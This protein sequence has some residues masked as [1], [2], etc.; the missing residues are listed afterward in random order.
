MNTGTYDMI[1]TVYQP[2]EYMSK[3]MSWAFRQ[4]PFWERVAELTIPEPMSGCHIFTGYLNHD[5]YGRMYNGERLVFVHRVVW[6]KE[7]GEIPDGLEVCHR[8]DVRSCLNPAHLFLGTHGE[9][10]RDCWSKGRGPR[11]IGS[12]QGMSKLV[13][14]DIPNIR[15]RIAIGTSCAAIARDYQVSE[16]LIRHIKK[17]RSWKHVP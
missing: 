17:R 16:G 7:H 4:L 1:P 10:V 3:Q 9:N 12:Q 11:L 6:I 5:G 13:E 8:C 2:R 15:A 14:A